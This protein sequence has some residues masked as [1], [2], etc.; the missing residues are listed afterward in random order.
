MFIDCKNITIYIRAK[1][2]M[3]FFKLSCYGVF[4]CD[5]E[6]EA[7]EKYMELIKTIESIDDLDVEEWKVNKNV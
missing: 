4:E 2:L 3:T 1:K 6:E 7:Y 5:T